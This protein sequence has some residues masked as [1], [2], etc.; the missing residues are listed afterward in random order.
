MFNDHPV[1]GDKSVVSDLSG[2]AV[3]ETRASGVQVWVVGASLSP[4]ADLSLSLDAHRFVESKVPGGFS[5]DLGIELNLVAS[6]RLWAKLTGL[7]GVNRLLTGRFFR[8]AAGTRRDIDY[9]YVQA[10]P[11]F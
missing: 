6:Y 5:R 4:T 10:T 2:V 11:E 1:V 7:V 3:R 8:Q 9:A